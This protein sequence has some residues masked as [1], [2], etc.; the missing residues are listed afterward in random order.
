MNCDRQKRL[1]VAFA[2]YAGRTENHR[3][4]CDLLVAFERSDRP[5]SQRVKPEHGVDQQ[6]DEIDQ[7]VAPVAVG[8]LVPQD[9]LVL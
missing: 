2:R 6:R 8:H 7:W 9:D 1:G 4:T 3:V 5:I